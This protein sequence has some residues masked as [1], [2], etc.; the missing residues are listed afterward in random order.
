MATYTTEIASDK[1][2][3]DNPIHQRLLKAYIAA[4]PLVKGNL[5]EVGCGEGRGVEVLMPLVE[6]Y[7]G[8]DK[9]QEVIDS[10]TE[11]YP[12]VQFQQAVIPPFKGLA[13]NSFDSVVSFQVIEH[14]ANDRLYLEE[15]YRVL[16]PGGVAVIST[17][18]IRHTLSRNPWHIREYTADQLRDLCLKVFDSVEA[19]GIGGNAKVWDY[20]EANRISVNKIMRFDILNLQYRLPAAVLRWPYEV[21]NRLNR[22][23]LHQQKG[24]A[25]T[26]ITHEDYL[27]EE[28]PEK[29]LD[30][31]Y[32]LHKRA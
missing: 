2:S 31:F 6:H 10:L 22:N 11:K 24:Q 32:I 7:L 23:K 28:H 18:N 3:S 26:D 27:V 1:I 15:I 13:A 17:P 25:V 14:I 29:G 30:L 19:K 5:L 4:K 12:T 16:K 9:I 21:L 20:H 8:I